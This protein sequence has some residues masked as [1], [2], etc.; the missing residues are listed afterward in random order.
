MK[1]FEEESHSL[2]SQSFSNILFDL[3]CLFLNFHVALKIA[4][5]NLFLFFLLISGR[6]FS[7][8]IGNYVK[9]RIVIEKGGRGHSL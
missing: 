8:M 6:M 1:C 9:I 4:Y 7:F 3:I 2:E 5:S